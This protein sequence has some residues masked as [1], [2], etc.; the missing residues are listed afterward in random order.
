MDIKKWYYKIKED[1]PLYIIYNKYL[2]LIIIQI[3][4]NFILS[5][6]HINFKINE[7]RKK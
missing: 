4:H 5:P 1:T 3:M 7:L 2:S 6:I